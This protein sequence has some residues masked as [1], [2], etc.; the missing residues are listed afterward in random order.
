MVSPIR[1]TLRLCAVA[2]LLAAFVVATP[3]SPIRPRWDV[4]KCRVYQNGTNAST[5]YSFGPYDYLS[6]EM[7]RDSRCE[8]ITASFPVAFWRVSAASFP[9]A[10]GVALFAYASARSL[11]LSDQS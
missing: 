5:S 2:A 8:V 3:L 1:V 7:E 11:K 6:V 10:L 9:F 4:E